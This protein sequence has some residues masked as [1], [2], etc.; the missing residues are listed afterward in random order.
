[1]GMLCLTPRCLPAAGFFEVDLNN[2]AAARVYIL[3]LRLDFID[4]KLAFT[5]GMSY[6]NKAAGQ[7]LSNAQAS[8]GNVA[9]TLRSL[10]GRIVGYIVK[11]HGK[12]SVVVDKVNSYLE[13]GEKFLGVVS[14]YEDVGDLV[15][16]LAVQGIEKLENALLRMLEKC[17][18][19]VWGVAV[20]VSVIDVACCPCFLPPAATT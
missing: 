14:Q 7:L 18:V 1:M 19:A 9:S 12:L 17:V 3:G 10:P 8:L 4:I 11:F 15:Q 6:V 13:K 2:W 5:A 20:F 16:D